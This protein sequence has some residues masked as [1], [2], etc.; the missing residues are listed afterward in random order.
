MTNATRAESAEPADNSAATLPLHQFLTYRLARVQAKLNT[1]ANRIL[2]AT[3]GITLTQWRVIALVGAAGQARLSD[4]AKAAAL[5]KGLLSRA[6]KT[7]VEDGS[8]LTRTDENDHRAQVLSLSGKGQQIFERTLPVTRA[9]QHRL[10]E[11]LTEEELAV[12]RQVLDKLEI[13]AEK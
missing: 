1:Q 5:D 9:R 13:A 2:R 10:R 11:G 4:L 3:S 8:I 7:L 12:F 6:V